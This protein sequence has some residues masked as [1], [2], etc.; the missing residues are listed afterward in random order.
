MKLVNVEQKLLLGTWG[1]RQ[2]TNL[3]IDQII[4][5]NI[6]E[7]TESVY[8]VQRC[9]AVQ[10]FNIENG[11][12]VQQ[13]ELPDLKSKLPHRYTGLYHFEKDGNIMTSTNFGDIYILPFDNIEE[14]FQKP[15]P[16]AS[17]KVG[18]D[19]ER[20]VVN[21]HRDNEIA[22]GGDE[23][24]LKVWDINTQ[25][26]IW[27]SKNLPNNAVRLAPKIWVKDIVYLSEQPDKIAT[28]TGHAQVRLYDIK[29][30]RRPLFN[31]EVGKKPFMCATATPDGNYLM[32]GNTIGEVYKFDLRMR[33]S[34]GAFKGKTVGSIRSI[35]VH[36]TEPWISC[37]SLDRHLRVFDHQ[38][39]QLKLKVYLKQRLNGCVFLN[40]GIIDEDEKTWEQIPEAED[41]GEDSG[42]EDYMSSDSSDLEE[43]TETTLPKKRKL[44]KIE[45]SKAKKPRREK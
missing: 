38:S 17:F 16:I 2:D 23:E 43:I 14:K 35:S 5:H 41:D 3:S 27:N 18:S 15:D 37:A 29:A 30:Q 34:C 24:P 4:K 19:I 13:I 6:D 10:H 32:L 40:E 31:V 42:I 39:R 21:Y 45:G 20:A 36:P 7:S 8:M 1:A 28:A 11:S 26:K 33:K 22:T 9:G 44:P 25:K 12:L